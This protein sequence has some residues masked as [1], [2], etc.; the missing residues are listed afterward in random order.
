MPGSSRRAGRSERA[1]FLVV[2]R[3]QAD[4]SGARAIRGPGGAAAFRLRGA[5]GARG[6]S[7]ASPR[8][9]RRR[10][11]PHRSHFLV[12]MLEVE[13]ADA[14]ARELARRQDVSPS[15]PTGRR[16]SCRAAQ[17]IP[18]RR[19][20]GGRRRRAEH[21]E[22]PR[23]G[24]LGA[25]RSPG[26]AS[27]SASRTPASTG[28]I[29]PSRSQYRGWNGSAASHAYNW[30]DAIHDAAPDEPLRRRT[31]PSPATTRATARAVAGPGR[32]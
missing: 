31:R 7:Q 16:R 6:A 25:G 13:A 9:P 4:L 17:P 27:W 23:A 19:S 21:R 8:A 14:T 11:L 30:H 1:S 22:R 5:A 29:R 3:E 12:N 20:A 32:R 15:R 28:R 18:A 10:G 26:R 24:G 2:L